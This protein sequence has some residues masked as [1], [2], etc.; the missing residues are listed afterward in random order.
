[1]KVNDK[2]KSPDRFF[3]SDTALLCKVMR[4]DGSVSSTSSTLIL[5]SYTLHQLHDALGHKGTDRIY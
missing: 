2:K 3:I 4:A 1:M 5:S